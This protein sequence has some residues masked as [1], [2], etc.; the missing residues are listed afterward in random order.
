MLSTVL[1]YRI[2]QFSFSQHYA[3]YLVLGLNVYADLCV[4]WQLVRAPIYMQENC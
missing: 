3:V 1:I 4:A 2:R